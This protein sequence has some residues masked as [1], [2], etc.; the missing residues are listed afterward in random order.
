MWYRTITC[1]NTVM[2]LYLFYKAQISCLQ[3]YFAE[4]HQQAA[5]LFAER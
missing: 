3:K 1:I 5:I 2:V 4:N